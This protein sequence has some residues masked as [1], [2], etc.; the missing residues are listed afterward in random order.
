MRHFL[1]KIILY[2]IFLFSILLIVDFFIQKGL[3]KSS[4]HEISKWN[5]VVQGG[6]DA[7][8]LFVGSSRALV[9]FDPR[10]IERYTGKSSFNL[11]LDGSKFESQKLVLDLYLS[12]IIGEF[13]SNPV[14]RVKRTTS[15]IMIAA[16]VQEKPSIIRS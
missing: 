7:D 2:S 5:E 15:P 9:H 16:F 13:N 4:Y 3:K 10:I 6:I 1:F 14:K 8:I 12:L 11:G